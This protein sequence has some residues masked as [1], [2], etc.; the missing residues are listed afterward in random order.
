MRQF[1]LVEA[2]SENFAIIEHMWPF[3]VYDLTRYC[4]HKP[5]WQ[6]PTALTFKNDNVR[7]YFQGINA[8]TFLIFIEKEAVGFVNIKQLEVMPEIDWYMN[9]FYIISKYQHHGIGAEVA[10]E[11]LQK[12]N[13]EWSI[14]ILPENELAL[15]FWRKTVSNYTRGIFHEEY[16]STEQ[17]I[18]NEHP[19]PYPMIMLR[20]KS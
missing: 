11:I 19:N 12:F 15:R 4:G 14:G 5:D 10:K 9:E 7:H 6:N 18:T 17:L 13:G 3:Y 8:H 20:F 16:R 2:T 1:S